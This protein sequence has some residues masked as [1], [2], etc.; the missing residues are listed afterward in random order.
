MNGF[1]KFDAKE[2]ESLESVYE[3]LSTLVNVMDRKNLSDVEYHS[4]YDTLLQFEPHVQASRATKNHDPLTLIAHSS[5]SHASPS[6]SHSLQPYY[7]THPSS[8]VDSEEDYQSESQGDAQEDKL[9]TT[10]MLLARAI[11]QKFFTS[12]NNRL[13]TSS[14]TKNQ[15]VIHDGRVD[16]QT[17]NI[18]ESNQIVQRVPRTELNPRRANVQCYNCNAK[19]HYARDCPKPKV[20]DANAYGDETLEELTAIVI[21]MERIQPSYDNFETEPKYDAKAISE[22]KSKGF[23]DYSISAF[24]RKYLWYGYLSLRFLDWGSI[25]GCLSSTGYWTFLDYNASYWNLWFPI[26]NASVQEVDGQVLLCSD[27]NIPCL[28]ECKIVGQLLLD[29]P[30]IHTPTATADV[31]A[32]I[33]YQ[34]VVDKVSA[35]YMKF[36]AQP[37]Q[38]MF[39]VF[40]RCLTTRTSGHD[41]TK[42]NI[43]HI[44]H[45][46]VNHVHV[47]YAALLWWDFLNYILQK[48]YVIQYPCFTKL[49]IAD[50]IKKFD[51]IPLR[52]KE[53]YHS[54][55]D[56]IPVDVPMIQPQSVVSTQ[57]AHRTTPSALM[58]PTLTTDIA[59]KKKWKQVAGE[60]SSPRKSLKVTI[61]Q[62]KPSTTPIP[63]PGDDQERD[64]MA[65]TTLLSLTLHKTALDAEARENI[66]KIEKDKKDDKKDDEKAND[67]E[68]NDETGRV[69]HRMCGR[70]GYMIQRMEKKYV[71]DRE[72]W[73]VHGKVDKAPQIVKELFKSYVLNNMKSNLQ[74]QVADLELWDDAFRPQHHDDHQEDDAPPEE[75]K[76][77]KRQKSSKSLKSSKSARDVEIP[78]DTTP[79]LIDE[80]QNV[81]KH[82]PTIYDYARTMATL[83]NVM[84]NQFKDAEEHAYH[85]E[86]TKNYMENQIYENIKEKSYILSLHKI[87]VVPFPEED[88][89]EKITEDVRITTDQ[90]HGLD[91]MVQIIMMRE[92]GKPGSFSKA[93]FK[94]LNKNGIEDL[95]YLCLNKKEGSYQIRV[96]LTAPTLT[97]PG[98]EAHDPYFIMD[99]PILKEVK[100]KIFKSEPWKKPPLLGE[101]DLDILKSFEREISKH[102]RH[103]VQMRMWESFVNGRPILPAMRR[104]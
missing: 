100:L 50:L 54:I 40:N 79:E 14:N 31:P 15:A 65:E 51:S 60:T 26:V 69:I 25:C 13:R 72:F 81:D 91:Y 32:I 83:N 20:R 44:F 27:Q 80:F 22:A 78:E 86:Q 61:K 97:F 39:K 47:D 2:G 5:Q 96:N 67:D 12:T 53:D 48:K 29:H 19:G 16:I 89:E 35:F 68:K 11:T 63:P 34:G 3:S 36:L 21:M 56:D 33:G 17:K 43:L 64:N 71:T 49:I 90:Q 38:T 88:L 77:A 10:M 103:R 55:K 23:V 46:V 6:Y 9:T 76:R 73:K 101:L 1:D 24:I 28:P 70:Q 7:V 18:D 57:G 93:D 59:S 87:H 104:P 45:A 52:L 8:I 74:D 58:S 98:F 82:I 92:N 4:L 66:A 99:K 85:L 75:E 37:W 42:I 84:S 62:K 30:L 102:L 95:Y 41:Q 94:Y